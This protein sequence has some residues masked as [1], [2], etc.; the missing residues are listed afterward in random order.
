MM[1][2][3]TRRMRMTNSNMQHHHTLQLAFA[4]I[5]LNASTQSFVVANLPPISNVAQL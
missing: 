2:F 4:L 1:L 3:D 5:H